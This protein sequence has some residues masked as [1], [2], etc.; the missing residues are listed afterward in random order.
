MQITCVGTGTAVPERDRACSG[1]WVAAGDA[2]LLVDCGPGVVH[3]LA[4]L[5]VS[6][7]D[8]THL[9]LSHFHNDHIGDVPFLFFALHYGVTEPRRTPLMVIGPSGTKQLFGRLG[10]AFG[11]HIR[12]PAFAVHFR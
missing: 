7:S 6:W 3:S 10:R 8:L 12:R 2:R 5:G 1:Y 11:S 4:R 9:V